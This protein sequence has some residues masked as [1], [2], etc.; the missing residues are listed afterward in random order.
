MANAEVVLKLTGDT[1]DAESD[2]TRVAN[3]LVGVD[4]IAQKTSSD[5]KKGFED[6][7]ASAK[8][9]ND[10]MSN[11][12]PT[13]N[14]KKVLSAT[15]QLKK[16]IKEY[17]AAALAAGEGTAEFARN[18]AL[19]GQKKADL[20][21]LKELLLLLILTRLLNLFLVWPRLLLGDLRLL[22]LQ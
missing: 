21:D 17:E 20:K 7:A 11:P 5:I 10:E 12:K 15:Q 9:A 22:N 14:Q 13:E 2:L 16:E 18:I 19:A 1:T 4:K 6:V 8:K 3:T